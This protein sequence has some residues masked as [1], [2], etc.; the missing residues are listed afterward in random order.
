LL[1]P[2][3]HEQTDASNAAL[4]SVSARLL[5]LE[6]DAWSTTATH[7]GRI[8]RTFAFQLSTS[9]F[10]PAAARKNSLPRAERGFKRRHIRCAAEGRR[11]DDTGKPSVGIQDYQRVDLVRALRSQNVLAVTTGRLLPCAEG[12]AAGLGCRSGVGFG[13][14]HRADRIEAPPEAAP[15]GGL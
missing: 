2:W 12:M 10:R 3:S 4:H 9:N 5:A 15:G 6:A 14:G 11:G 7:H 8:S 1:R 13:G